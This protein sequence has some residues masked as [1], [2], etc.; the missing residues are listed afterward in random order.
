[1]FSVRQRGIV[2]V[3]V[4]WVV[5]LLAVMATSFAYSLRTETVLAATGVERAQARALAE[6]GVNYVMAHLLNPDPEQPWPVDGSVQELKLGSQ[7][8]QVS[9]TDAA[10]MIDLNTASRELLGGL[11]SAAGVENEA[12]NRLVDAIE[13]WR[14]PDDLRLP[15]GAEYDDYQAAGRKAGPK[16]A[17][18][19]SVEELQQV[20]GM[21]PALYARIAGALTVFSGQAG[22]DPA[23]A[24]AP[25]LEGIP[26]IDPAIV[27]Q[28]LMLRRDNVAQG[29][30]PPPP[31]PEIA[32]YLAQQQGQAYHI[33]AKAYLNGRFTAPVEAV[34]VR[35]GGAVRPFAL[36]LWREG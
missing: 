10:G 4:L 14:D 26:G 30:P 9:V 29:L 21:T 33:T 36:R 35:Q 1:M 6:A 11:L 2:L 32:P 8:F 20:L 18:F 13:D 34:I 28:Y 22:I 12:L 3:I 24:S 17:P 23:V 5:T 27:E 7:V 19:D 25:V 31:P 16:N 15:N